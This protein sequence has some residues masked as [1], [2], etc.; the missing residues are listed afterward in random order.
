MGKHM[1]P[2][3][4]SIDLLPEECEGVVAWAAQELAKQ[5]RTLS[6]IYSEFRTKLIA[7]QGE[8]GLAF[9]I[10][11]F[12]SFGRHSLRLGSLRARHRR[13]IELARALNETT[14]EA[15]A[16]ELTKAATN[17]LKSLV[18]ELLEYGGEAGFSPKEALAMSGAIKQL[19]QA[20]NISTARRQKVQKEFEDKAEKIIDTVAKEKGMSAD[21][22]AQL[23][24]DFLGV[25]AK[26]KQDEA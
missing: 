18:F 23:R 8:L 5:G 13:G 24:R 9:D 7:L 25:R 4:S 12:S 17:T 15:D 2:R 20:E 14:D 22:I 16:D 10:P 6:D 11:A 26:S 19:A 21:T 1:R 3:P